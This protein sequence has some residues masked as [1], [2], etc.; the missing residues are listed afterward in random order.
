LTD[1]NILKGELDPVLFPGAPAGVEVHTGFSDQFGIKAAEIQAEV[2][3][4]IAEKGAT[5]VTTVSP[6]C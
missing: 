2:K 4:L 3:K 1:L 6:L 5:Q